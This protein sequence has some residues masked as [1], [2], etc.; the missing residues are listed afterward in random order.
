MRWWVLAAVIGAVVG[1]VGR[2]RPVEVVPEY[3]PPEAACPDFVD[4]G[5]V[6]RVDPP[7]AVEVYACANCGAATARRPYKPGAKV[8]C[9]RVCYNT[10]ARGAVDAAPVVEDVPP[11]DPIVDAGAALCARG[12][13]HWVIQHVGLGWERYTCKRCAAVETRPSAPEPVLG[14]Q[15]VVVSSARAYGG[16][17]IP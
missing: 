17:A 8:Y 5:D 6:V 7:A 11:A 12:V 14:R 13:H 16:S 2:R 9:S 10:R 1:I 3:A 15:P 4:V